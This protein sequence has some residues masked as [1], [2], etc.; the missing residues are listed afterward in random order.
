MTPARVAAAIA[1]KLRE[2]VVS[3]MV[4]VTVE[5][6]APSS[7]SVL[8]EVARPGVYPLDS[9]A[10]VLPALAAAG[11]LTQFAGPSEIY[12][13]RAEPPLRVRFSL[14]KLTEAGSAA[15]TFR[16]RRGDVVVVE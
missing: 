5:E 13:V 6:S 4:T 7:I 14:T 1:T 12:V 16:L 2:Y 10:A 8:G 3:P 9:A 11:G 15:A